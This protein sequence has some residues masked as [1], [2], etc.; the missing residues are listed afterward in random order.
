MLRK[1]RLLI[2]ILL[3]ITPQAFYSKASSATPISNNYTEIA[4]QDFV[5]NEVIIEY[6]RNNNF[7]STL[8][9][10]TAEEEQNFFGKLNINYD[11]WS[12]ASQEK[13]LDILRNKV[14]KFRKQGKLK[15]LRRAKKL[16]KSLKS[17][18]AVLQLDHSVTSSELKSLI[19]KMN[20][21]RY[22]SD[23]FEIDAVYPNYIYEV[24]DTRTNDPLNSKQFSHDYIKPEAL[25]NYTKGAGTV[26]AVIDTGVDWTHEDLAANIWTN[27]DEIPGNGKDDDKNGFID[28][29]RGWD[30][31]N[32][33]TS[34]CVSYEDCSKEDNDPSDKD[35]HG[36]HV[37]V[38]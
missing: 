22:A 21:D 11:I 26:V 1:S 35:G 20:L 15:K 6:H 32:S 16:R 23:N 38:I 31:V 18:Y 25:W 5:P 10:K 17:A 2:L 19:K 3:L 4:D 30:F 28:D 37:A 33:G 9:N 36:T 12:E 8:L 13:Q 7:L 29:V 14:K 27:T 34:S 24:T